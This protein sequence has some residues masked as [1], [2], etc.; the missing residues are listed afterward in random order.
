MEKLIGFLRL[1]RPVNCLM[2]GFA[3]IV[4]ASLVSSLRLS[5]HLVLGFITSF[6]LTGASM[7]INDY[8]DR[9]IDAINEPNRPIP[10]GIISPKQALSLALIL[11]L[12]GLVAAVETDFPNLLI[13]TVAIIAL[14]VSLTYVT[15]GKQMGLPGN[16]LVSTCVV[17]PFIYGSLVVQNPELS[18]LIFAAIAFIS[19]TGR[20]VAKGIVDVEGDGSQG[21]DTI[22]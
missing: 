21:V 8:Y 16:L 5:V 1:I 4:G 11:S 14:V 9:E 20:E 12:V 13:P 2:M 10:S 22:A 3:V 18:I 15:K 19:N 17:T 6:T 7:A